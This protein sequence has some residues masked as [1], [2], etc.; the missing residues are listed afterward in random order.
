MSGSKRSEPAG[1]VHLTDQDSAW[2]LGEAATVSSAK[3][4]LMP[5]RFPVPVSQ[6]IVVQR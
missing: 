6:R 3:T 4:V 2:L 5:G 1:L